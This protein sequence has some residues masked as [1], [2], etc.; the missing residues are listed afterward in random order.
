[1]ADI[2]EKIKKNVI[3]GRVDY[4]DEGFDGDMEGQPGVLELVE[5]A[6]EENIPP[7]DILNIAISPGMNEVGRLYESGEYLIP[8]MLASAECVSE[9]T[10]ILE[11]L[12]LEG[13]NK[14]RGKFI[15][16]TV[17]D[18]LHDIGKNIVTTLLRGSGFDVHDLGTGIKADKIVDA[19][20]KS[21]AKYL[22][23]SA[24]LTT[25]MGHMEEVIDLLKDKGIRDQVIVCIGGAPISE[26]FAQKIGAD[27]YGEDAF[28]AI[29]KLGNI[30]P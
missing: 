16:A 4:E 10:K 2:L 26:D 25:T 13:E 20:E 30:T 18:D 17:E 3:E 28:D 5:K 21:Q 22:G 11:P 15:I 7:S 14:S 6:L 9:A 8:D 19:I 23:L 24:L 12:L 1:M 29:N 27:L